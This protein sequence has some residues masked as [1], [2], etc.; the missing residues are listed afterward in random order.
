ML[1]DLH[2]MTFSD[3]ENISDEKNK[4]LTVRI[5]EKVE[6]EKLI[7]LNKILLEKK[8]LIS[9]I[10]ESESFH[11]DH[12]VS[13]IHVFQYLSNVSKLK[14]YV[15][16][17]DEPLETLNFL[18]SIHYLSYLDIS[19][20][21]KKNL[22]LDELKRFSELKYFSYLC[23]GLSKEQYSTIN[24]FSQM[25]CL[26]VYDLN[27]KLINNYQLIR[28]LRVHRKLIDP[29][30]FLEKFP[31]LE[32]LTLEKCNGLDF[33]KNI[34]VQPNL[35][36]VSLRYM[37]EI[38]EIPK[39]KNPEKIKKLSLLGLKNLKSIDHIQEMENLEVLEI[40]HIR[41]IEIESFLI[42][43]QLKKLKQVYLVF[44]KAHLN[45]EFEKFAIENR[46]PFI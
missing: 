32:N 16:D 13:G 25:E 31:N 29:E 15:S 22:Q 24:S 1:V 33:Q 46:L 6:I 18:K 8:L 5:E 7:T 42:L 45:I 23:E 11:S 14:I 21:A 41:N 2:T 40:T 37:N 27:L 43:K 17:Y 19:T 10:I 38:N 30:L 26:A 28:E 34:A 4:I 35:V 12:V 3:I 20:H 9:V 39:F 36:N 44:E